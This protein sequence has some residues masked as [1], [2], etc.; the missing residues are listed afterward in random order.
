MNKIL[1]FL[2]LLIIIGN[3]SC[4]TFKDISIKPDVKTFYVDDFKL[5]ANGPPSINQDFT[6]ELKRKIISETRLY[7]SETSAHITFTGSIIGYTVVSTAPDA[8]NTASLNKLEIKIKVKFTNE[9]H[10]DENWERTFS[11][12]AN[13]DRNVNLIEVQEDLIN[14]IFELIIEDIINKS[15]SNW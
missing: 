4:Y 3:S 10:D 6:E 2:L 9:L 13:F 7:Q 12:Y 8:Q 11:D 1:I 15:F 5:L 14:D